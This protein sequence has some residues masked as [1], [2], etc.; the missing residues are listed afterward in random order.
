ML[1]GQGKGAMQEWSQV[2]LQELN[3]SEPP[4]RCRNHEMAWKSG[5]LSPPGDK[6]GIAELEMV[7]HAAPGIKAAGPAGRL[8]HG[9]GEASVRGEPE[10][11]SGDPARPREG[12]RT[13]VADEGVV[14]WK[15]L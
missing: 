3:R 10:G 2:L 7:A 6:C 9:T 14:V 15:A 11:T 1:N 5:L 12:M 4:V 8:H 13:L